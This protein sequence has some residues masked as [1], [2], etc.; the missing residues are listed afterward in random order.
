MSDDQNISFTNEKGGRKSV[1][2]PPLPV[3]RFSR[4]F[5]E[6]INMT[7][8][9]KSNH[10]NSKVFMNKRNSRG[11]STKKPNLDLNGPSVS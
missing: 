7:D 8:P 6:K 3:G 2:K 1:K 5:N 10:N 4:N 11:S 9:R